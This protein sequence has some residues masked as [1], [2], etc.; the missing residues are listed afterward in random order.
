MKKQINSPDQVT[1]HHIIPKS[2]RH[3]GVEGVCKVPRLLHE[4][5][6]HLFGNMTPHEILEWLNK[7]FWND[8]FQ[9]TIRKRPP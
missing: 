5:Y 1:K 4:L 6:H 3:K 2:R 7:T 8:M 9:I